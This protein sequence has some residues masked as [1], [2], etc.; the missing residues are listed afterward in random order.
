MDEKG[1]RITC[2]T[3]EDIVVLIG[4]KEMYVGVPKNRLSLTVVKS[5]SADGSS[6]LPLV[7]VPRGTI[8]E[9]WFHSNMTG[10]KVVTVSPS[11]YTNEEICIVWLDHF[12]DHHNCGPNSPWRVLLI[13]GATCHKAPKFILKA[14]MNH[15]WIVK[16]PSHQT[17]LLQPL[18]VGC[19]R[20]WKKYQQNAIMNIIRL[21]EP[22][23]NVQSFFRDLPQIRMSTFKVGTIKHAF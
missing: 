7:I 11:G 2:P 6:I 17:H 22:E 12:I 16:F 18:D 3:S 4:I 20:Q 13:D 8:M 10:H 5:I 14:K 23:Y 19:F 15:I 9:S 1:Y 21:F